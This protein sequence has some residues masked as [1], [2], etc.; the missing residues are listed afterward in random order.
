M[1]TDEHR[2]EK[3]H[4][5]FRARI[6]V[7]LC[8][9]VV[10]FL[11]VL[12]TAMI[13]HAEEAIP[14]AAPL[15]GGTLRVLAIVPRAAQPDV[16]AMALRLDMKVNVCTLWS[17][18]DLECAPS[19]SDRSEPTDQSHRS[20]NSHSADLRAALNKDYDLILLGRFRTS[21]L[22]TDIQEG[23]A[24]HV[25][26]GAGLVAAY[27][28]HGDA[29]EPL[30]ALL[31]AIENSAAPDVCRGL[32]GLGVYG[33]A[34][35]GGPDESG[36]R[37]LIEG[38]RAGSFGQGRVVELSFPGDPPQTHAFIPTASEFKIAPSNRVENA[39]ALVVRAAV[40][41]SGRTSRTRI[42][43][44]RDASPK[45]P[46]LEEVPPDLPKEYTEAMRQS[47][48]AHPLRPFVLELEAPADRSYEVKI[49]VRKPEAD[50]RNVYAGERPLRKGEQYWPFD[51]LI[52]PGTYL[53]DVWLMD[54]KGVTDWF[55]ADVTI[56]GW[57][58]FS[59]LRLT[60]ESV[61]ANDSIGIQ[62]RVPP[63]FNQHRAC[64]LY[65][66]A[67]DPVAMPAA[68]RPSP[69]AV[70]P[71]FGAI[72]GGISGRCVAEALAE[73][74]YDGGE[75]QIDLG[76]ADLVA[77][78]IK[79]EVFAVEGPRH[80]LAPWELN[81]AFYECRYVPVRTRAHAP[82]FG[83]SVSLPLLDEPNIHKRLGRLEAL[84]VDSVYAPGGQVALWNAAWR[85]L[86]FVPELTRTAYGS[87]ADGVIRQPCLSD[88]SVRNAEGK[89]LQTVTAWHLA[90]ASGRYSLGDRAILSGGGA[91]VC[92]S[93]S[94]LAGFR[95]WLE[96]EYGTVQRL[97]D[98]WG[99]GFNAWEEV[100]P[101]APEMAAEAQCFA[102]FVDFR[103]YMDSV[104]VGFL[105]YGRDC[106]RRVD[107]EAWIGFGVL[108]ETGA[109]SGY[110]WRRLAGVADF[111]L[112]PPE[113][114]WLEK[115]RSFRKEAGIFSLALDRASSPRTSS[116]VRALAWQAALRGAGAI[117]FDHP[118][119]LA[120]DPDAETVLQ[121]DGALTPA[122]APAMQVA[123]EL[124]RGLGPLLTLAR[125]APAAIALY[126]STA[127]RL[128]NA[129]DTRYGMDSLQA[130]QRWIA[131]LEQEGL[132][133]EFVGSPELSAG[134]GKSCRVLVLP[135]VR[136]MS[137]EEAQR[138]QAFRDAGGFVAADAAPAVWGGH[139]ERRTEPALD[140][141]FGIQRN[142]TPETLEIPSGDT[143]TEQAQW[144]D[145]SVA[146]QDAQPQSMAGEVPLELKGTRTLLLNHPLSE[147][148]GEEPAQALLRAWF[149]ETGVTPGFEVRRHGEDA[150]RGQRF[151]LEYHG[152]QIAAVLAAPDAGS[153]PQK[154]RLD[155]G[156]D[157]V[158]YDLRQSRRVSHPGKIDIELD[159]GDAACF[160]IFT[161][162]PP[163]IG[164][165]LSG[166][167]H[168][169]QRLEVQ[170]SVSSIDGKIQ[171]RMVTVWLEDPAR[172][173]MLHYRQYLES[174]GG[175]AKTY[176]PLAINE[177]P[178]WYQAAA[179][180]VLTGME[181]RERVFVG[182]R[183]Q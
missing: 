20:Q 134:L 181:T 107:P 113:T 27:L 21:A 104:F 67:V 53:V 79:I 167:T 131:F 16:E 78:M 115:W 4:L 13:T 132:A 114:P 168:T 54:R 157:H 151:L 100:K 42:A 141:L 180:D 159:A 47:A 127:S 136:A 70:G 155:L 43:A 37:R 6:C 119:G 156:K 88:S 117:H 174:Q 41:A 38:V 15:Q 33:I 58:R 36:Q 52:G 24:D 32:G 125:R 101:P 59:E 39:Y 7:H 18:N 116:E 10:P 82:G 164:L 97:N 64:T 91:N 14:W 128:L 72:Y 22:P 126:D 162:E 81:N 172:R 74:G 135:L 161:E 34:D 66:R 124:K 68:S 175:V 130:E 28:A 118:S 160:A 9:S 17:T 105:S 12:T 62:L 169:G 148:R 85:G 139:G 26:K 177:I 150:F 75:V 137:S 94:C 144:C 45:A 133:Y 48:L 173:P 3:E 165:S 35:P 176:F 111:V 63:I 170:A 95:A 83:V 171:P 44:L 69:A 110:D 183:T 178:G 76:L 96:K 109:F 106:V 147:F 71:R 179:R 19:E 84:G 108:D 121:P 87:A 154:V 56:A 80:P 89:Q 182:G 146:A 99:S 112:A 77:P 25:R 153:K 30:V 65:A 102:G 11:A 51:L 5:P 120:G 93:E 158:V 49:Q 73:V 140:T 23:I 40:W 29:Q 122:F 57:P 90:G 55:S 103:R 92:Q 163:R 1:N 86:A 145:H 46:A 2:W 50:M 31:D 129:V 8:S 60:K 123:E 61:L 149:Q 98:A 138:V 143:E 166:E 142:G 152:A